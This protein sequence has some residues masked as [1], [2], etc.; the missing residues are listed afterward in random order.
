[1]K[2]LGYLLCAVIPV[3][4]L[5]AMSHHAGSPLGG[6]LQPVLGAFGSALVFL[7]TAFWVLVG[8]ACWLTVPTMIG[9]AIGHAKHAITPSHVSSLICGGISALCAAYAISF[10]TNDMIIGLFFAMAILFIC[11]FVAADGGELEWG[12]VTGI[13]FALIL[14]LFFVFTAWGP[15]VIEVREKIK[16]ADYGLNEDPADYARK[17]ALIWEMI[18]RPDE[19]ER[20]ARADIMENVMTLPSRVDDGVF[21][22]WIPPLKQRID[23]GTFQT[24]TPKNGTFISCVREDGDVKVETGPLYSELSR[25]ILKRACVLRADEL[26]E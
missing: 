13:F 25:V 2:F 3:G 4:I 9:I 18:E 7:W 11:M 20:E 14:L 26:R 23:G 17:D 21:S 16:E 19:T 15:E 22:L 24:T 10:M 12:P 5:F 1:M 6:V 8:W